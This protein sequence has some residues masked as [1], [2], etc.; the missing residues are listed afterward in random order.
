MGMITNNFD[1]SA[2]HFRAPGK[3]SGDSKKMSKDPEATVHCYIIYISL[4]ILHAHVLR[5]I[6]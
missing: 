1:T 4:T 3:I 5:I 6:K 2:Y